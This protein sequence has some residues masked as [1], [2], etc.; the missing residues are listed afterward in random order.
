[1]G[2]NMENILITGGTGFIG[3]NLK[4]SLCG[5]YHVLAPR[6]A[7][8]D[9]L[10]Y[11]ALFAYVRENQID[12]IIHAAVH[13]PEFNGAENEYYNDMLM[14][15][16]LEKISPYVEKILYFGSGAEYDKRFH[17]RNVTEDDFG[18]R[19]PVS[20]YGLGKYT[21]TK[22]ARASENIYNLRL[23]GIFGKYELWR[24]KFLSNLCCK[25][26]F[27]LPLTI[28]KDC[29]FN[30][31]YIDDLVKIVER[32]VSNSPKRHDLNVC[33]DQNYRLSELATMVLRVSGKE[34]EIRLLSDEKNLDYTAC[35]KQLHKEIPDF[36]CTVMEQSLK[37]L[38]QH[39]ENH[40]SE[41]DLCVLRDSR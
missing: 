23:F 4:E 22:L 17:I 6:H 35:N 12:V 19:I 31:L 11:D 36:Q 30:F 34:L 41:I 24:V 25:A 40:K 18:K 28:R 32:F 2:F 39:Y 21:M 10:D 15:L 7:E 37:L 27:D 8:L 38:Y 16:N 29:C 33:H 3:R 9:L 13:V 14:F 26:V 20:E 1:M 5:R